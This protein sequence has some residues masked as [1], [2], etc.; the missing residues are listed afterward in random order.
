[1]KTPSTLPQT[2]S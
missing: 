1:M 2:P